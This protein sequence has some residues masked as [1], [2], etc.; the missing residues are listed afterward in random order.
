MEIY[1]ENL[2]QRIA[3]LERKMIKSLVQQRV[4]KERSEPLDYVSLDA[5]IRL[6]GEREQNVNSCG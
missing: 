3:E 5:R 2:K 6:E 1:L 4:D